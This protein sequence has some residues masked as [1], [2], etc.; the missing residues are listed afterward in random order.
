MWIELQRV[1]LV[2][3]FGKKAPAV[4]GAFFVFL[5]LFLKWVAQEDVFFC[6]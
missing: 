4:A 6:R 5:R 1:V 3:D 2:F